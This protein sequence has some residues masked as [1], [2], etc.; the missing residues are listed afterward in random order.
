[1]KITAKISQKK[2]K[3]FFIFLPENLEVSRILLERERERERER[4]TRA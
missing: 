1:M 2:T 3:L 4:E